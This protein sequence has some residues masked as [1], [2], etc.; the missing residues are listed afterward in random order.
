MKIMFDLPFWT[1]RNLYPM[2]IKRS[3]ASKFWISDM[4][5]HTLFMPVYCGK[6]NSDIMTHADTKASC[7]KSRGCS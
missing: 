5:N 4:F 2:H 6:K 3:L 1:L 7:T